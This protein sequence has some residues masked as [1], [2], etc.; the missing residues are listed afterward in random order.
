MNHSGTTAPCFSL[1][2]QGLRQEEQMA[3][4]KAPVSADRRIPGYGE[5]WGHSAF[6]SE[7]P[8]LGH[9]ATGQC[10]LSNGRDHICSDEFNARIAEY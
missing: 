7:I 3:P 2:K 10:A 9:D 1:A 8:P 6:T 5:C 4:L